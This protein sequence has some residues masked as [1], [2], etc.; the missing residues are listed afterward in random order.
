MEDIN[1]LFNKGPVVLFKWKNTAGWPV[2]AVSDNVVTLLGYCP[3]EVTSS[4]FEYQK[5]LHS[6][7]Q[8]RVSNE[9]RENTTIGAHDF[10]HQPYRLI[11]KSGEVIWVNDQTHIIRSE[12][13]EATH[14]VGYI[15][16]ITSQIESE[17]KLKTIQ[18]KLKSTLLSIDDLILVIDENGFFSE[19]YSSDKD[20]NLYQSPDQFIGK[21][22][23]QVMPED[24]AKLIAEKMEAIKTLNSPISFD[25]DLTINDSVRY[26]NCKIT[27]NGDK[28]GGT[29]KYTFVIRNITEQK[30]FQ[31]RVQEYYKL[32]SKSNDLLAISTF[33]G[34]VE[35]V[36]PLWERKFGYTQDHINEKGFLFFVHPDDQDHAFYELNRIRT[37]RPDAVKFDCRVKTKNGPYV[38]TEWVS[39]IDYENKKVYSVIRDISDAKE[40]QARAQRISDG[41]FN[42]VKK[43][44][45]LSASIDDFLKTVAMDACDLLQLD[46]FTYWTNE[47][48]KAITCSVCYDVIQGDYITLPDIL[49]ERYPNYFK[50]VGSQ[51]IMS[52]N[53]PRGDA[54][55]EELTEDYFDPH[56]IK[57]TMDASII[58]EG[59]LEGVLCA[60]TITSERRWT[61][62][63]KRDLSSIAE[64]IR[65][66]LYIN[67]KNISENELRKSQQLMHALADHMPGLV[68][69]KKPGGQ[70]IYGNNTTLQYFGLTQEEYC[71]TTSHDILGQKLADRLA[72]DDMECISTNKTIF[73]QP[74]DPD[75][76]EIYYDEY[77][78]PIKISGEDPL[79]GGIV[80]NMTEQRIAQQQIIESQAKYKLLVE[81]TNAVHW[82]LDVDK[83]E[84]TYMDEKILELTG[85]PASEFKNMDAWAAKIN[86]AERENIVATRS[87]LSEQGKDHELIYRSIK[88]NGDTVWIKDSV[89]VLMEDGK[90]TYLV[91]YMIDITAQKQAEEELIRFTKLQTL[92]MD[93]SL[94]Y[95]NMPNNQVH[96]SVNETL[97]KLGEF[98]GVDRAYI[99]EYADDYRSSTCTNSW[100]K[101]GVEGIKINHPFEM[102]GLEEYIDAHISGSDYQIADIDTLEN[103]M[104]RDNYKSF[105]IKSMFT[106][107]L[108][109]QDKCIGFVGFDAVETKKKFTPRETDLLKL[110]AELLVN[111]RQKV[112]YETSLVQKQEDL[113]KALREKNTL[114]REL[115]HRIKN[116]LQL[117]SSLMFIKLDKVTDKQTSEFINESITR[118]LSISKIHDQLLKIEE[119]YELDIK[120]YLEEL[121]ANI[122]STYCDNTALYPLK[123][124]IDQAK[125]HID[126]ALMIGLF[127]NEAVSNS[128]KYAYAPQIGGEI[129]IELKISPDNEVRFT[130]ADK[131]KGLPFSSFDEASQSNGIQL[132]KVF[133]EQLKG[134]LSLDTSVGTAYNITFVKRR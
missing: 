44:L 18:H 42:L 17:A 74:Q 83:G 31:E 69:I 78:F 40:D 109:L 129:S 115:H 7:D 46:R 124:S 71:K 126:D 21:H 79:V 99:F 113:Q 120:A 100:I 9:V 48:D 59:G 86:S 90:P 133:V 53:Q 28:E 108:M 22:F 105:N 30:L 81:F 51:R 12:N 25:Y 60:E 24:N 6:E 107:P 111:L 57:S 118:I 117:I 87:F 73:R 43:S 110:F 95:I 93:L 125:F 122:M 33:D 116:N 55:F 85:Y 8:K 101:E 82:K 89:T 58:G 84:F 65:T 63:D 39:T 62:G 11:T 128:I 121:T 76:K 4:D 3:E 34:K 102:S 94:G 91:G 52:S 92:L 96:D 47:A 77:K 75:G 37:D 132:M 5:L 106:M 13:G 10:S 88:P 56:Q 134:S 19:F 64:I 41:L 54:R 49:V 20:E 98:V 70:H 16:D 119:V 14:Y 35:V 103:A 112:S 72:A 50:A 2:E 123:V 66:A 131:G 127:I 67:R 26:F 32:F 80:I 23:K 104:I 29:N 27:S 36:N 114:F 68:Y 97:K 45:L 61:S 38:W 15:Y 1:S 130:V